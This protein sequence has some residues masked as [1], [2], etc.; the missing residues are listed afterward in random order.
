M[1]VDRLLHP[2]LGKSHKVT[3][4]TDMEYRVWTQYLLSSDDF[5]VMRGTHHQLQADNDHLAN[6][7]AKTVQRCLDALVHAGLVRSFEHQGRPYIYQPDWQRWQKVEYPRATINPC[8][9]GDALAACDEATRD[10]FAKHP[11]GQRKVT[12]IKDAPNDSVCASKIHSENIPPT[13]AGAPAKRPTANANGQRLT[14]DGERKQSL[15]SKRRLDAAWE[16][17]R[18]YVPQRCHRDFV[19]LRNGAEAELFAW[20]A[21]TSE[22]WTDGPF[23]AAETGPDMFAFWKARYAEKWPVV[24]VDKRVPEW[25]R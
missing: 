14:A 12:R 18:V 4:L 10:L 15:I 2:R 11:G 22:A 6:R 17:P 3:M 1:P 25:A 7:P 21:E 8:L 19:A 20:Y 5:G 9:T 23:K 24:K 16:G 13:R